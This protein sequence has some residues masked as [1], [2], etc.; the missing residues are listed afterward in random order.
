MTDA[1]KS[2]EVDDQINLIPSK[3]DLVHRKGVT[4]IQNKFLIELFYS[5][6]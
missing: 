2:I 3:K 5:R 4:K 1:S 6:L